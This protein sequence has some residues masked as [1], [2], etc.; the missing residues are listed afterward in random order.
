MTI[1]MSFQ[2]LTGKIKA[3]SARFASAVSP[4]TWVQ[5]SPL[6]NR[7]MLMGAL[8]TPTY[9]LR[10]CEIRPRVAHLKGVFVDHSRHWILFFDQDRGPADRPV[11]ALCAD[12]LAR[13][14]DL[15]HFGGASDWDSPSTR[16][17]PRQ[18]TGHPRN[19]VQASVPAG[20][21]SDRP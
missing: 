7:Q 16:H 21:W 20:G 10:S 5:R 17:R 14:D 6:S 4:R 13:N 18:V 15:R 19:A 9:Y 8:M 11:A 2:W 1:F 3:G 12:P